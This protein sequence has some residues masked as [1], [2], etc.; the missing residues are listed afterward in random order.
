MADD[1]SQRGKPEP[2]RINIH[3][4]HEMRHWSEKFGVSHDQLREAVAKAGPMADAVAQHLRKF[5]P[6]IVTDVKVWERTADAPEIP[7]PQ[8][9]RDA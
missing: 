9:T 1:L 8:R 6:A 2:D 7:D 4:A 3:E 5:R